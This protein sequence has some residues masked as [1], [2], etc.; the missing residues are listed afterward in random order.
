MWKILA[1]IAVI[2][3][4]VYFRRGRNAVGG[5]LTIGVIIGLIIAVV[6]ASMGKG[7][8]SIE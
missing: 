2:L 7:F 8:I 3:S 4:I 5:G 1:V 6:L